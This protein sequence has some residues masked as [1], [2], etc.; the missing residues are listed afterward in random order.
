MVITDLNGQ[1]RVVNFSLYNSTEL[2]QRGLTDWSLEAGKVRRDY[3]L[4]SFSYADDP[5]GSASL[6][7]GVSD[8]TT[9][10]AHAEATSGLQMAGVGGALL[11]GERGGVLDLSLAGSRH[12]GQ[13]GT[14]YGMGYQWN[15]QHFNLAMATLRRSDGFAD[16]ASLEEA[17][18]PLRMDSLFVGANWGLPSGSAPATCA[19]TCRAS[20]PRATPPSTGR[21]NFRTAAT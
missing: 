15:S 4:R 2:L 7:H 9:L 1:S 20:R 18:L 10:E 17:L 21:G 14:Q 13:T 3:G 11:L 5:M 16:V 6:R 19:R 12:D 8:R